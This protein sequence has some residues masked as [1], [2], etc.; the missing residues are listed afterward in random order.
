MHRFYIPLEN[1]NLDHLAL[2]EA[3]THHALDVLRLKTGD[4]VVVFNGRGVE[5]TAE[6]SEISKKSITLRR[7]HH[8]KSPPLACEI[9]LGQAIPKG[10]NMDLIIQKATELGATAIA[11]LLSERTVIQVDDEDSAKKQSKWQ[12]VAIEAAKQCGQNWLPTV[13]APRTPKEF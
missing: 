7:L 6:I 3:E 12:T 5:A 1:W 8:S 2:D 9:T 13:H 4:R 11:P 10:K